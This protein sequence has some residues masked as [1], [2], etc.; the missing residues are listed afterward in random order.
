MSTY[1]HRN[2][3]RPL[4]YDFES[5]PFCIESQEV[6]P[7]IVEKKKSKCYEI[8]KKLFISMAIIDIV[9]NVYTYFRKTKSKEEFESLV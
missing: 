3:I 8:T 7:V 5:Q 9:Y 1:R 2:I 6:K 4:E